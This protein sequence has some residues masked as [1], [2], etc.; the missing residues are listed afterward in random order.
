M[1]SSYVPISQRNGLTG[2]YTSLSDSSLGKAA[3]DYSWDRAN[4]NP[5]GGPNVFQRGLNSV[6]GTK[7]GVEPVKYNTT[8]VQ[9]KNTTGTEGLAGTMG[10]V[11][12]GIGALS[13]VVGGWAAIEDVNAQKDANAENKLNNMYTYNMSAEAINHKIRRANALNAQIA[14]ANKNDAGYVAPKATAEVAMRK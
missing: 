3:N 2:E 6:L 9:T 12:A 1:I 5:T 10:T 8:G 11:T 7:F 4:P 13:D 14:E